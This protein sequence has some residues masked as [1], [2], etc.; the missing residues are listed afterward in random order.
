MP[1]W[2]NIENV[3]S[4]LF[5]TMSKAQNGAQLCLEREVSGKEEQLWD[6][7]E[8]SSS[9]IFRNKTGFVADMKGSVGPE[10]IGWNHHGGTNQKFTIKNECFIHCSVDDKVWDAEHGKANHHHHP[11]IQF[12]NIPIFLWLFIP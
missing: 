11:N 10:L 2:V 8:M 3:S 5:V 6:Y 4:G 7:M 1:L 9:G 12:S